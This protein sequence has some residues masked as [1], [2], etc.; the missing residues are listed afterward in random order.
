M[1]ETDVL[2]V[3][4]GPVGLTLAIHLQAAGVRT[5]LIDRMRRIS[6]LSRAIGVHARTLECLEPRGL[7]APLIAA[8]IKLDGVQIHSGGKVAVDA[9]LSGLPTRYPFVLCLPQSATEQIL[10]DH[11]HRIG[12]SVE[13]GVG[14]HSF[15]QDDAGVT[16]QLSA[17][18]L[19]ARWLVGCDGAHSTVRHA[20]GG[21]FPG[22]PYPERLVLGDVRWDT[23][24]P[25]DRLSIF[26]DPG[27]LACFPLPDGA[28]RLIATEE[29]APGDGSWFSEPT[30]GQEARPTSGQESQ[31]TSGQE[32]TS[33]PIGHGQT[34]AELPLA[35]LAAI[36]ARRS[37]RAGALSDPA[38]LARFRIHARQAARYR[39]GRVFLA[40][41]AAHI[42]SPLGAQ[43]MNTGM[44]DAINLAWKLALAARLEAAGAAVPEVLLESYHQ[45]RH[46]VAAGVLTATDVVT[47]LGMS[48]NPLLMA[49]RGTVAG[50]VGGIG[51]VQR[52]ATRTLAELEVGYPRSPLVAGEGR[53]P[54]A[55]GERL[56]VLPAHGGHELILLVGQGC[57]EAGR[58]RLR[59]CAGI[60][61]EVGMA[62]ASAEDPAVQGD[63]LIVV[64]PDGYAGL[65]LSPADP[66]RLVSWLD[67]TGP[68]ALAG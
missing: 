58:R 22:H 6:P 3:G 68:G 11:L 2:I 51:A 28:W 38:W 24:L 37:G 16:A 56:P 53:L 60:A 29:P 26:L 36:T 40:G 65:C 30:S 4:A 8:G 49:A 67:L 52:Q 10:S 64:R 47:R 35:E 33:G 63:G 15:S 17:G 5:R 9:S 13:R 57:T 54:V 66:E 19:R 46:P 61:R 45:E 32:A 48:R 23:D 41:D 12:G 62:A 42:H 31:P 44:Q 39:A 1:E 25:R 18:P 55:P 59:I 43:G 21:G 34:G 14:L 7:A 27:F 50:F 20:L